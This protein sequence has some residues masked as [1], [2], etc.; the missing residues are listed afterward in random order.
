M[1]QF[2]IEL[3]KY[4][5]A[6]ISFLFLLES[7]TIYK[8]NDKAKNLPKDIRQ[9]AYLFLFHFVGYAILYLN[10]LNIEYISFYLFQVISFALFIALFQTIYPKINRLLLNSMCF[11]L[12]IGF[13]TL[14]RLDFDK[15]K[16][17]YL[18]VLAS[19][20][21]ALL[22]PYLFRKIKIW[23]KLYLLYGISGIV[24]L[25]GVYIFGAVTNGSKISIGIGFISFQPQELIK[26]LYVFFLAGVFYKG[27][28]LKQL[29]LSGFV[30]ATH[31]LILV[32]SRDLGSAL[33]F[34]VVYI[35][36]LF[37][38]TGKIRYLVLGFLGGA[39]SSIFAYQIFSHVRVRVATWI[40]P[41][42]VIDTGGYQITQSLF[43]ISSGGLFGS[44]IF[45]GAAKS[46]P[47]VDT[48]FIF[49]AIA[50]E[51]GLF[52]AIIL[53]LIYTGI[54][55]V[56]LR[57]ADRFQN[58]FYRLIGCG[59][60]ITFYFQIFL[61]IGGGI[62]F[63]PLTGVTL[64]LVSY[65]GSSVLSSLIVFAIFQS[66]WLL[67]Q[68][69]K[70]I[71]V[72][73]SSQKVLNVPKPDYQKIM[74]IPD[75]SS[76]IDQDGENHSELYMKTLEELIIQNHLES[77]GDHVATIEEQFPNHQD[78]TQEIRKRDK[79]LQLIKDWFTGND[80]Y[81]NITKYL[82][83]FLFSALILYLGYAVVFQGPNILDNTYNSRQKILEERNIRG[84][85][86]SS[87]GQILAETI[88]DENGEKTRNYPFGAV[89]SHVVG[90]HTKGKSGIEQ[91]FN[92]YLVRS[93]AS[94]LSRVQNDFHQ[95]DDQG[96]D[97]LTTLN[98][99]VQQAAFDA[100]GNQKGA[101]IA[102]N[103]K[104]GEILAM[105]SKPD[106]DPENIDF[107]WSELLET[108]KNGETKAEEEGVL[109]NRATQGLYPPGSTFK[110]FTALSFIKEHQL[111]TDD[112]RFNCTGS[113]THNLHTISCYH[114]QK[115][116]TLNFVQSFAKSCNSS[117]ANI[118]T[119]LNR[120][121]LQAV[122]EDCLFGKNLNVKF[123]YNKSKI[124]DVREMTE[125][126][127]LQSVIGQ[128][129]T[130]VTPLHLALITCGI[131]NKGTIMTPFLVKEVNSEEG[132]VIKSYDQKEL[133]QVMSEAESEKLKELMRAVVEEGTGVK[134]SEYSFSISGKTG[135]AEY[136]QNKESHAWF[137]GF[138]PYDNPE[139]VVCVIVEGGGSG[140]EV[141]APIAAK[142][143]EA[144]LV[145][146][147]K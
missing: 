9:K 37:I 71:L 15:A 97:V 1:D 72:L 23:D 118:G 64:P 123:L 103:P 110:I 20:A 55:L 125:D 26:V 11:L 60:A 54:F 63:I 106:F 41:F 91:T 16:K 35:G 116:G 93:S 138:A 7:Y 66:L 79:F 34:S 32:F 14:G 88:I 120:D 65:G 114:N 4:I 141:A 105:V 76:G 140:G 99:S 3:S 147:D 57:N 129:K 133:T 69:E 61:T 18:I 144:Y 10:T 38:A 78:V 68:E 122:L 49:S 108:E 43:A 145:N 134:V 98:V 112:Y 36:V 102:I 95:L 115:H 39:V 124:E 67:E 25:A 139:I 92:Y 128:G 142:V 24:L 130:A 5:F 50:E 75:V 121:D 85:I 30:A 8:N 131:A 89:F 113:Y 109:L 12:T 44:G 73:D 47:F 29:L 17:Q 143:M 52:V 70:R 45:Q 31:I 2:I 104:T 13:I 28:E 83:L 82:Y 135:S 21:I 46:I 27:T 126:M 58:K 56:F 146:P 74:G 137:T 62:K 96:D 80:L 77:T 59:L 90:Y 51:F 117:F 119:N 40:N 48:D 53:I 6:I 81:I 33:I 132:K 136:N 94:F 22:I 111:Q 127:L 86:Y 42:E 101:V 87:D 84:T 19:F 100:M 107:I